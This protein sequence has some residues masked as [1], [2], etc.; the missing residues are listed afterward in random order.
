MTDENKT[1]QDIPVHMNNEPA[2]PVDD[3]GVF[4]CRM[5]GQCCRGTGGI[6]VGPADLAR[7]TRTLG[8]TA[9]E[10]IALYGEYRGGKLQIRCGDDGSCIFF[11]D[12]TGCGVHDG[13]PDVCRAW[14]FFRGNIIDPESLAMAKDFCPG[15]DPHCDH[16][17][18]ARAGLNYL[19]R[20]NLLAHDAEKEGNA[21]ILDDQ[22]AL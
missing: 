12:G 14:P 6:V 21:V 4:T 17:S 19:K 7:I 20:H 15:I 16:T 10:F 2:P 18:F 9:R 8:L 5:C 13:K 3:S 22:T 11:H 1:Q